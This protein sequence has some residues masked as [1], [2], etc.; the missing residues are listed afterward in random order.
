M[1]N[2]GLGELAILILVPLAVLYGI[3]RLGYRLGKAE[4]KDDKK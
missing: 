1:H 4:K 2:L 3:F